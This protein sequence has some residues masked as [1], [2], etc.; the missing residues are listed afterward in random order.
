MQRFE[1]RDSTTRECGRTIRWHE[2]GVVATWWDVLP[3]LHTKN[4]LVEYNEVERCLQK[5]GDGSSVNISGAGTGNVIRRNYIHDI[6]GAEGE[7]VCACVRT[8]DWQRGT[9]ITENVIARSSTSAFEH[10]CENRF[11]NNV[12]V[13]VNREN[14]IRF[15]R[16]WGPF[17][18]SRDPPG[19]PP[20]PRSPRG[21]TPRRARRLPRLLY[22]AG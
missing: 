3:F 17:E 1:R 5:L 10:K 11:I 12:I 8:D 7:W 4:N 13:D 20:S 16:H 14:V 21:K 19:D 18:R 2:V 6:F 15:G 22:P 9:L